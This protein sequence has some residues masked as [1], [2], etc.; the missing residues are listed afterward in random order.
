MGK[1]ILEQRW[2]RR[3]GCT[4]SWKCLPES[5][6][7]YCCVSHTGKVE[8][9]WVTERG[10]FRRKIN[11]WLDVKCGPAPEEEAYDA[12]IQEIEA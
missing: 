4:A 3:V 5:K 11:Q 12:I 10:Q 7:E 6:S 1:Y 9:P 8:N 2:C